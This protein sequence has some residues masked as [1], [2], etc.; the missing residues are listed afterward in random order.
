MS[1]RSMTETKYNESAIEQNITAIWQEVLELPEISKEVPFMDLGGDSLSAMA[2]IAR[3][4]DLLNV[5]FTI[6]DFFLENSTVLGFT[7]M[8]NEALSPESRIHPAD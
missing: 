5:E 1:E 8:A 7:E 4:R 2:C 3:M 6:E